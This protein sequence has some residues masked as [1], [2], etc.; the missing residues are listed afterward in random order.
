M[1][2]D[3]QL[4]PSRERAIAA[5]HA[6]D[7]KLATDILVLDVGGV[8]GIAEMFV[9]ASAGNT[10]QSKAVADEVELRLAEF[11][12]SKPLRTEGMDDR[13]WI[14]LDYGDIVVHVFVEETREFYELE[15]LWRDVESVSWQ[16]PHLS[17]D[18]Q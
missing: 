7:A 4:T 17:G 18:R 3:G 1:P 12:G 11:D 13:Q 14:L 5:A 6:A 15:R 2:G 10:R 9:I 8:L 16:T